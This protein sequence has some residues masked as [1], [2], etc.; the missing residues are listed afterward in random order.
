MLKRKTMAVE[1]RLRAVGSIGFAVRKDFKP[2]RDDFEASVFQD[3]GDR[4][5][6]LP[7][8]DFAIDR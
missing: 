6:E 7:G 4:S 2:A 1:A 5:A 8:D 3:S